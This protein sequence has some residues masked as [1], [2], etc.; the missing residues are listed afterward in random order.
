MLKPIV[1]TMNAQ[2]DFNQWLKNNG[3]KQSFQRGKILEYLVIRRVSVVDVNRIYSDLYP[4]YRIT[5][6]TIYSTLRLLEKFGAI[7]IV[8]KKYKVKLWE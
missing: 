4:D 2:D 5:L 3:Y 6:A 1:N 8:P 7:E